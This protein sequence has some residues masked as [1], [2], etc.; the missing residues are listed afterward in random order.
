MGEAPDWEG[1]GI[2]CGG[3]PARE[4]DEHRPKAKSDA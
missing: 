1:G 2:R 4:G 3:D